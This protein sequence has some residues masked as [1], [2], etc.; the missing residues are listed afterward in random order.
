MTKKLIWNGENPYQ[1]MKMINHRPQV[2][3]PKLPI[4]SPYD[5]VGFHRFLRA[6]RGLNV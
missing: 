2:I 3:L 1:P 6:R 5:P 4:G